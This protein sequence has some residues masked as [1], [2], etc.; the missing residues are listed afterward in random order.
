M[1]QQEALRLALGGTS[2]EGWGQR[3]GVSQSRLGEGKSLSGESLDLTGLCPHGLAHRQGPG[4]ATSPFC[5]CLS[6]APCLVSVS[7]AVMTEGQLQESLSA[8]FSLCR[9]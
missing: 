8:K 6:T 5:L 2:L 3:A 4:K 7:R 1:L 9:A